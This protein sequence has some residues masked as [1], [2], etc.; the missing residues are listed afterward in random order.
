MKTA[1]IFCFTAMAFSL[2]A[3]DNKAACN[4]DIIG[5]KS[6]VI[7]EKVTQLMEAN[8]GKITLEFLERL[9]VAADLSAQDDVATNGVCDMMDELLAEMMK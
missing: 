6:G 5:E 3:C 1:A 2:G 8:S 4:D 7:Q 9:Q